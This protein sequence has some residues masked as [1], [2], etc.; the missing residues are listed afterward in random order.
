MQTEVIKIFLKK[1]REQKKISQEEL[2][3]NIGV[4]KNTIWRWGVF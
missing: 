2:G 3:R 4:D 1:L